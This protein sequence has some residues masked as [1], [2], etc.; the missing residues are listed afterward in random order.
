MPCID[1]HFGPFAFKAKHVELWTKYT[2]GDMYDAQIVP[3]VH[4]FRK[5]LD[6]GSVMAEGYQHPKEMKQEEESNVEAIRK[7]LDQLCTLDPR[8]INAWTE[9]YYC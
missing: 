9:D 3:I 1:W 2:D 5:G 8:V 6:V 4:A 7:R